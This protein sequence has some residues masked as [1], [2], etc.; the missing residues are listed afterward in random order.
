VEKIADA[1]ERPTY[2]ENR[3]AE[4]AASSGGDRPYFGVIP[5]YADEVEGLPITGVG[6]ESPAEKAGA[7]GGDVIVQLGES[8][9]TGIEDFDSALR[10][11][12]AG[13]T[14]K[15]KVKRGKET[16]ELEVILGKPR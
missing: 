6:P 10:K 4:R 11:H 16:V 3:T 1:D 2:V 8:K 7:K 5:D 13:E 12:K 14:V 9:I 15:F